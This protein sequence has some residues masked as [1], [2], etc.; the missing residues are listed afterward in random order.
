ML[1]GGKKHIC[2]RFN[3][4]VAPSSGKLFVDGFD[5]Y[6]PEN[7]NLLASWRAAVAHVPQNIYLADTSIAQNIAFGVPKN[8]VD[9]SRQ[10]SC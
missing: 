8:K 9:M 3:G 1:P 4:F 6:A 7:A 10:G 5:L 2:R